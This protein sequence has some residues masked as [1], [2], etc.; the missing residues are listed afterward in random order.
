MC[1]HG[2]IDHVCTWGKAQEL[3]FPFLSL[4]CLCGI[5]TNF[6]FSSSHLWQRLLISALYLWCSNNPI[7]I[8]LLF[9]SLILRDR[10][11]YVYGH[12]DN[13][14]SCLRFVPLSGISI[15]LSFQFLFLTTKRS[16]VQ[17]WKIR[18]RKYSIQMSIKISKMNRMKTASGALGH[19]YETKCK[20]PA[21]KKVPKA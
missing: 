8:I 17:A 11:K 7:H 16:H 14:W 18:L 5:V 6:T 21:W 19:D 4:P 15:F 10:Q 13:G 9:G 12:P 1:A 2:G 3:P 20:N